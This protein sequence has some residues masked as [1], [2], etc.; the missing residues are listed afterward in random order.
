MPEIVI[1]RALRNGVPMIDLDIITE[2]KPPNDEEPLRFRVTGI[3]D[4]GCPACVVVPGV[5]PDYFFEKSVLPAQFW[6]FSG[7]SNESR[8]ALMGLWF[9]DYRPKA[10]T[11]P[12]FEQEFGQYKCGDAFMLVGRSLL[13]MGVLTYDGPNKS[14]RWVY[15]PEDE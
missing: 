2:T 5:L 10:F 14:V 11:V 15:T 7:I 1:E 6:M 13:D 9:E 3:I 12:V 8:A 4:T